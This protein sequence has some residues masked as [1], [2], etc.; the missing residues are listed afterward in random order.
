[1]DTIDGAFTVSNCAMNCYINLRQFLSCRRQK[2]PMMHSDNKTIDTNKRCLGGGFFWMG[3]DAYIVY[4]HAL[5]LE[6]LC[7]VSLSCLG[8]MVPRGLCFPQRLD[9]WWEPDVSGGWS[10]DVGSLT[11]QTTN[12]VPLAL[13]YRLY[14]FHIAVLINRCLFRIGSV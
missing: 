4:V 12:M 9:A 14:N 1:M 11:P 6:G 5:Y 3:A 8:Y 10:Q 7:V 2:N 13:L